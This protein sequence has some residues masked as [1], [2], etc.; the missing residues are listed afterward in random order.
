VKIPQFHGAIFAGAGEEVRVQTECH[1][2]D[3]PGMSGEGVEALE[4]SES[5]DFDLSVRAAAG[6]QTGLGMVA[7]GVRTGG[8]GGGAP[9]EGHTEDRTAVFPEAVEEF[10]VALVPEF[11]GVVGAATGDDAAVGTVGDGVDRAAAVAVGG[12]RVAEKAVG[13][14]AGSQVPGQQGAIATA[15]DQAPPVGTDGDRIHG[16]RVAAKAVQ[17]L[18]GAEVPESDGAV[19]AA[20]DHQIPVRPDRD[21][22]HGGRV[23]FE[24]N[25]TPPSI[26]GRSQSF[27]ATQFFAKVAIEWG[28]GDQRGRRRTRKYP[29][30]ERL[31][32]RNAPERLLAGDLRLSG[33]QLDRDPD[34]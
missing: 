10:P 3:R 31:R 8:G 18:A 24:Y 11:D 21:R 5:P 28:D 12:T 16:R 13:H 26:G 27:I 2:T 19:G 30:A 34:L 1:R 17:Q 14:G 20:A 29:H 9:H 15:A 33:R 32:R 6:K 25:P 23:S 7:P 22:P 4:Q